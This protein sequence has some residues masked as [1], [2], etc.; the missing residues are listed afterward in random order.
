[1]AANELDKPKKQD[2]KHNQFICPIVYKN[3]MPELGL[4]CKFLPCG[5]DILE[6]T[7]EPVSFPEQESQHEHHFKGL[8]LLFDID[9]VNQS[10]YDKPKQQRSNPRKE[11]PKMDP[12]D[13]AL[14]AD[15]EALHCGDARQRT[16]RIQECAQMFA[17]ERVMPTRPRTGVYRTPAVQ[18]TQVELQP[19]SLE[20]Q[21]EIINQTFEEIKKPIGR[22]PIK[23]R[24]N[25]KPVSI[26]PLFPDPDLQHYNFLQMQFDNPPT[27]ANQS[28][29][30]DCGNYFVNFNATEELPSTGE[31]IY[32]SEQRYKEDRSTEN[33]EKGDRIILLQKHDAV[34]YVSVQKYMKLR[35]ERPRPQAMVN[36]CLLQVKRVA[37]EAN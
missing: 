30:K 7:V 26:L 15:I 4:D 33:A 19:V 5:K 11:T 2:D 21:K 10:I 34:Y 35:R 32:V 22:H 31:Q 27:E 16:S 9:L 13:A 23:Q 12:R 17:K 29:I 6:Y 18:E 8:H 3:E 24:S 14:L 20:Q 28:L 25:A 36:K 37:K 1:M